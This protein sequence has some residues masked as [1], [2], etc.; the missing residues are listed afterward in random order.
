MVENSRTE[1][2]IFLGLQD[3]LLMGLCQVLGELAVGGSLVVA[4]GVRD[5]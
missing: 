3:S 5:R 4:V 2:K 1:K